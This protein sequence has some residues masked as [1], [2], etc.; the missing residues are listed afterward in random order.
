MMK[1]RTANA[2]VDGI[3]PDKTWEGDGNKILRRVIVG[4]R[5]GTIV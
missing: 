4:R 3:L 2:A 1:V 5:S